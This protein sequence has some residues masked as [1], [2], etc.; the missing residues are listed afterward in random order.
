MD[1][2]EVKFGDKTQILRDLI[3]CLE[4]DS[5]NIMTFFHETR[6]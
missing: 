6:L 4:R 1:F 5:E 3:I 2:F